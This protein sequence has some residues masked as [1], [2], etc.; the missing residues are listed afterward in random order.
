[1]RNCISVNVGASYESHHI[2]CVCIACLVNT[3]NPLLVQFGLWDSLDGYSC[4]SQNSLSLNNSLCS[5]SCWDTSAQTSYIYQNLHGRAGV[6]QLH[7][8][9]WVSHSTLVAQSKDVKLS[10][11]G[12]GVIAGSKGIS[13]YQQVCDIAWAW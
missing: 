6:T 9:Q 7:S 2:G 8:P 4:G 13:G 10:S 12:L 5:Y 1:M 3:S 11:R